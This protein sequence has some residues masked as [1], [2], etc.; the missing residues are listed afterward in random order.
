MKKLSITAIFTAMIT[1]A[2]AAVPAPVLDLKC[3]AGDFAALQDISANKCA[4]KIYNQSMISWAE[5]PAGKTL[6]FKNNTDPKGR[7][8]AAIE[9]KA[10][11]SLNISKGFTVLFNFKTPSDYQY[12]R[13]YQLLHFAQGADKLTGISLFVYWRSIMFRYGENSRTGIA[14]KAAALPMRPDTWYEVAVTFDGK[15]VA[16]YIN[17]TLA[18]EADNA[19][20][21]MPNV[22][23]NAINIG[24]TSASGAGYGFDGLISK[25][26]IYDRALTADEIADM[27]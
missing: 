12:K 7:T 20:I 1:A 22:R 23:R 3:N 4:V 21:P 17:G 2:F 26:Q 16:L 19:V 18:A 24:A 6:E 11:A 15:K 25:V 13:R 27:E 5:G 14:S 8:R 9:V 10:P